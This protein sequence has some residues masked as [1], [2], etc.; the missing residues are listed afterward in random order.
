MTYHFDYI[1][2]QFADRPDAGTWSSTAA[3]A[4]PKGRM[5]QQALH[6]EVTRTI[7]QYQT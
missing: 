4:M 5:R 7:K 6:A 2:Y 1:I 3:A